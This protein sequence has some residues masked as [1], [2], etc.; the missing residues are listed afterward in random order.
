MMKRLKPGKLGYTII[1]VLFLGGIVVLAIIYRNIQLD[2]GMVAF[3]S[4]NYSEAMKIFK[5]LAEL[6]DSIPQYILGEMFAFGLGVKQDDEQAMYWFRRASLFYSGQGDRGA[7]A[8]C[9]VAEEYASQRNYSKALDWYLIAAEG[10]S[11][12][13]AIVLS[14]SYGEGLLG[15]QIDPEQALYWKKKAAG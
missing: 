6:G 2:R 4:E 10:G 7:E 8:A 11:R 5:P 14:K 3:K 12:Q 15:L 13:A 1:F 9:S